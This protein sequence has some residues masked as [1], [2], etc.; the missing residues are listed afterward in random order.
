MVALLQAANFG[1]RL[2]AVHHGHLDIHQDRVVMAGHEL[3]HRDLAVLGMV[4]L[5]RRV[6]QIGFDQEPIVGR[7][8][9]Q[10]NSKGLLE[11]DGGP[12]G[13]RAFQAEVV[14]GAAIVDGWRGSVTFECTLVEGTGADRGDSRP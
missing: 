3:V 4:D 12:G 9:R 11:H 14:R 1:D 6:L 8:F 7:V 13:D 5:V 10:E 2:V